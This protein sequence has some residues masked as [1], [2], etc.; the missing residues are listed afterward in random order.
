MMTS[1]TSRFSAQSPPGRPSAFPVQSAILSGLLVLVPALVF[2]NRGIIWPLMYGDQMQDPSGL[3]GGLGVYGPHTL[4]KVWFP[5]LMA[6]TLAL[7]FLARVR[8]PN[9]SMAYLSAWLLFYAWSAISVFWAIEPGIAFSRLTLQLLVAGCL[10]LAFCG[11]DRP[12]D[13]ITCIYWIIVAAVFLNLF[14]VLTQVPTPLGYNG[15]FQHKNTL[16]AFCVLAMLFMLLKLGDER[17]YW[18]IALVAIPVCFYMLAISQSKTSFGLFFLALPAGAAVAFFASGL[19]IPGAVTFVLGG[20]ALLLLSVFVSAVLGMAFPQQLEALIGDATFTGR[21]ELWRFAWDYIEAQPMI[22]YGFRSF[23]Q[24]GGNAPSLAHGFGFIATAAHGHNGY[25]DILLGGGVIAAL[26]VLPILITSLN[27]CGRIA[28][29]SL[30]E[31]F[32]LASFVIFVLLHNLFETTFLFGVNVVFVLFQIVW[33]YM[34]YTVNDSR[35]TATIGE[36]RIVL[37]AQS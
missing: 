2:L 12:R 8:R 24:I 6:V 11:T 23:W 26:L 3:F 18:L 13:I 34:V 32:V 9:F 33:L 35:T 30:Y 15:I 1:A 21:T 36:T 22:G 25:I 20:L 27:L 14:V 10:Y 5:V 4:H 31:G 7:F 29:K 28:R 19:R 37:T 16:G 17:R